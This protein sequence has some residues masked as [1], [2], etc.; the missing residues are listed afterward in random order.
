MKIER[1]N[2]DSQPPVFINDL[3]NVEEPEITTEDIKNAVYE[4]REDK[5]PHAVQGEPKTPSK[6]IRIQGKV[7]KRLSPAGVSKILESRVDHMIVELSK[8]AFPG[9]QEIQRKSG[10]SLLYENGQPAYKLREK[11]TGKEILITTQIH[12]GRN[13]KRANLVP[14][15]N[16]TV[17]AYHAE[18]TQ[19]NGLLLVKDVGTEGQGSSNGTFVNGKRITPLINVEVIP[20][21]II[22]FSNSEYIVER[23]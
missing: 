1:P 20:G 12:V 19:R 21:D 23:A 9:Q 15:G 17:S 4:Q 18:I 7:T 14:E 22:S 10:T 11:Q 5:K 3:K 13:P 16:T 6:Q 2:I 8:N